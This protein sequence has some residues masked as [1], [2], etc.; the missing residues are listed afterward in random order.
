MDNQITENTE[1]VNENLNGPIGEILPE[2][3]RE[4]SDEQISAMV[5][6]IHTFQPVLEMMRSIWEQTRTEWS[7]N[8]GV[9]KEFLAY[10]KNHRTMPDPDKISEKFV[11]ELNESNSD[12]EEE[13]EEWDEFNG[14]DNITSEEV[15]NIVGI[16]S[17]IIGVNHDITK[18]HVK[19]ACADLSNWVNA[20]HEYKEISHA[21][22]TVINIKEKQ[23]MDELKEYIENC[24]E[25]EEK[26]KAIAALANYNYYNNCEFL[27][28]RTVIN[29]I[30]L[31]YIIQAST[32]QKRLEYWLQRAND[33]SKRLG[34][35]PTM[36]L[37]ANNFEK[38]FLDVEYHDKDNMLFIYLINQIK[39]SDPER[40]DD[41]ASMR[42]RAL[43]MA[44][45]NIVR[46]SDTPE[47]EMIV[48]DNIRA[49]ENAIDHFNKK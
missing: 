3:V 17:P 9:M 5:E 22:M 28:D 47:H 12:D 21:L 48:L 49:F 34:V 13:E 18:Q 40:K 44:I 6:M 45:D 15:I 41:K 43:L 10:N 26:E 29:D 37:E 25:G 11:N 36:I 2:D 8:D 32:D 27:A 31:N 39:Y 20:L 24:E 19:E 46:K 7:L 23:N 38:R 14:L 35:S 16:D 4:I 30:L 42:A 33:K 1:V